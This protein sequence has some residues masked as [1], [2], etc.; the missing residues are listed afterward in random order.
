MDR[1]K[2]IIIILL[3]TLVIGLILP[4]VTNGILRSMGIGIDGAVWDSYS[5]P[6]GSGNFYFHDFHWVH[7][8]STH[9][10]YLDLNSQVVW[11]VTVKKCKKYMV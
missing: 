7:I 10:Q 4:P 8:N 2:V 5:L 11:S 3:I 9:L 1:D 6:R